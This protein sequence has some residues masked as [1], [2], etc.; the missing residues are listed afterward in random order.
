M[1]PVVIAQSAQKETQKP[2]IAA[3]QAGIL[4]LSCAT[5]LRGSWQLKQVLVTHRGVKVA[6]CASK[7]KVTS[8]MTYFYSNNLY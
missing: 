8:L 4:I 5:H 2:G 1:A 7:R 3:A 6:P